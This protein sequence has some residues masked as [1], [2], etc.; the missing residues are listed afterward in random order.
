MLSTIAA[1]R[2]IMQSGLCAI[3]CGT[4]PQKRSHIRRIFSVAQLPGTAYS[5]ERCRAIDNADFAIF[6]TDNLS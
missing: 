1:A 2:K 3:F 5:R 6:L 4:Q